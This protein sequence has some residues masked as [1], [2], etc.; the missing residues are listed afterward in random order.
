MTVRWIFDDAYLMLLLLFFDSLNIHTF[1]P[2][3]DGVENNSSWDCGKHLKAL[4]ISCQIA[5]LVV[6]KK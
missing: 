1:S 4:V 6:L 5:I 3:L 2:M